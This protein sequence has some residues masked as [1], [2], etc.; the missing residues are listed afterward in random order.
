MHGSGGIK[1]TRRFTALGVDKTVGAWGWWR[2]FQEALAR[3]EA[4]Q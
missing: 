2:Y 4:V 1:V 3:G